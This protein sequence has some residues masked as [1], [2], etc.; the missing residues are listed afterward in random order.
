MYRRSFRLTDILEK[1]S[2]YPYLPKERLPL[3]G[4]CRAGTQ[5]LPQ[6]NRGRKKPIRHPDPHSQAPQKGS[7]RSRTGSFPS[8]RAGK[9]DAACGGGTRSRRP[10]IGRGDPATI[11]SA[12]LEPRTS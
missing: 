10:E 12:C 8:M 2:T 6:E 7:A 3:A 1:I 9:E 5:G 11:E 4:L